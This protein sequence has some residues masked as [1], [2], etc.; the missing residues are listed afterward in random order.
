MFKRFDTRL[1]SGST[2][3]FRA[4]LLTRDDELCACDGAREGEFEREPGR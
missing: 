3:D 1:G 2:I 4:D